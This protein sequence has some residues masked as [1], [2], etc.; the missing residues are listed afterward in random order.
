MQF[1]LA[2]FVAAI[3]AYAAARARALTNGGAVAAF[4]IGTI[5]FGI[6][7]WACALV[8]FAFFIPSVLLSR[9]GR[10][11]KRALIDIGKQGSRDAMQVLANGG[12]AAFA[13]LLALR[14]GG[15]ALA[16]FA[17]A[18]AASAA[19][20]WATEI[21]TLAQGAPRSILTLR[22]VAVGISG[23]VTSLGTLAQAGGAAVVAAVAGLTHV[24]PFFVVL[25][26]GVAG[27]IFDSVLGAS[28]QTLRYCPQCERVCETNP[29]VCGTPTM[30]RRGWLDNDAVN[31]G[32]SLFGALVAAALYFLYF[33]SR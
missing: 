32:A 31:V 19:D 28:V 25:V 33:L 29:H 17:G 14:W 1:A 30:L 12:V 3:V 6:G 8:L 13:M 18:F 5:V 22:P 16:A 24:A 7:G 9:I 15:V 26:A 23:G 20:T 27:S 10:D 21:G 11:R 4:C 2:A